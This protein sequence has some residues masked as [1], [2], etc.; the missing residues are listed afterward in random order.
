[1]RAE[2]ALMS[3]S[4]F[5]VTHHAFS[6]GAGRTSDGNGSHASTLKSPSYTKSVSWQ[7][8]RKMEATILGG[9]PLKILTAFS[10]LKLM[11]K[12]Y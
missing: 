12:C 11:K 3:G 8:Y 9:W 4:A 6:S 1:M 5:A 2:I 7:H 10:Q